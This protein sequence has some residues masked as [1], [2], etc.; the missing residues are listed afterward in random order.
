M[1]QEPPDEES[2][3]LEPGDLDPSSQLFE[4]FYVQYFDELR[5]AARRRMKPVKFRVV[6]EEDAAQSALVSLFQGLDA[7]KM[8]VR[9]QQELR[10]LMQ[11]IVNRKCNRYP[12]RHLAG[13]RGGGGVRGESVFDNANFESVEAGFEQVA[14]GNPMPGMSAQIARDCD[15]LLNMPGKPELRETVMLKLEGFTHGE[16][17]ARMNCSVA[18]VKHR[19]SQIRAVWSKEFTDED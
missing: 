3:I 15:V 10:G 13:K 5:A 19:T 9:G 6:D 8:E 12:E 16:I 14:D 4:Q 1:Y 7:G 11:Q 18:F 17:A 2:R